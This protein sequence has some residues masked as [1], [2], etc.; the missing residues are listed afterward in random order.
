MSRFGA[1]Q[2]MEAIPRITWLKLRKPSCWS[3]LSRENQRFPD[4]RSLSIFVLPCVAQSQGMPRSCWDWRA[5]NP[6]STWRN[7]V[8][9]PL[10]PH[11]AV[12]GVSRNKKTSTALMCTSGHISRRTRSHS[13]CARALLL[14]Q[15]Q[16]AKSCW[17]PAA[18]SSN[19]EGNKGAKETKQLQN[20]TYDHNSHVSN[21][22]WNQRQNKLS[23]RKK[24]LNTTFPLS[25]DM[26]RVIYRVFNSVSGIQGVAHET[27]ASEHWYFIQF[28]HCF[29]HAPFSLVSIMFVN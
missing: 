4:S 25:W 12:D 21:W 16:A 14:A 2:R 29:K 17:I 18:D 22:Q 24:L 27:M 6:K 26:L 9:L 1:E 10:L 3:R 28:N 11:V 8:C 15:F 5:G 7:F 23:T 20:E 13:L 19:Y